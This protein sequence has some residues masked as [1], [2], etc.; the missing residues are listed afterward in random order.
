MSRVEIRNAG[1]LARMVMLG[2]L[3][4]ATACTSAGGETQQSAVTGDPAPQ[5]RPTSPEETWGIKAVSLRP[6]LGGA[7]LDFRYEVLDAEKARPLF[8][9]KIKPYL[10]DPSSGVALG[11]PEDTKLGALRTSLR[12]PPVAGKHYY[13]LFSNGLGTVKSGS[14]VTV[15]IGDCKLEN[16]VVD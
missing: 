15:V 10:F 3:S 9:R 16:V 1:L 11:M 14:R 4:C 6:T 12:N 5:V 2:A 8:D 7:M 13:I